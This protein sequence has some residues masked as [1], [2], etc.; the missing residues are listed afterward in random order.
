M[1]G[2]QY[3]LEISIIFAYLQ[4]FWQMIE[5]FRRRRIKKVFYFD[6]QN[7]AL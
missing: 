5:T 3:F 7:N 4:M 2:I 6:V 1:A